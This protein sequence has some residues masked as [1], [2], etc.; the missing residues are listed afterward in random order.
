MKLH[1]GYLLIVKSLQG[2]CLHPKK[3]CAVRAMKDH[4]YLSI[5]ACL[6]VYKSRPKNVDACQLFGVVF[7]P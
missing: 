2:N 4:R 1:R 5:T 7:S 6:G 3:D